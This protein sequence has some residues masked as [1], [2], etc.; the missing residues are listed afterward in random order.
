[1]SHKLKMKI[2]IHEFDAEGPETYVNAK[3]EEFKSLVEKFSVP[4]PLSA[5]ATGFG[6]FPSAGGAHAAA[7]PAPA[8][9]DAQIS[10]EMKEI[11]SIDLEGR[12]LALHVHIDDSNGKNQQVGDA[13]LITLYGY[14]KIFNMED[15][16]SMTAAGVL[17]NALGQTI[18]IDNATVPLISSGFL[19]KN[20]VGRGMNYR[21]T[22]KGMA[23]ADA[24]IKELLA[25]MR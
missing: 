24:V 6:G 25:K 7:A 20:G 15:V 4:A 19:T 9:G 13:L 1:M 16:G 17:K 12:K 18:R 23:K 14:R 2:G 21:L 8:G 10:P 11:F 5:P 22:F 3:F